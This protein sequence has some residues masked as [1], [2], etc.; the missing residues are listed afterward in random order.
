MQKEKFKEPI[1]HGTAFAP[2]KVYSFYENHNSFFVSHHWHEEIEFLYFERGDFLLER[3]MVLEEVKEGDLIFLNR[4]QMHQITGLKTPSIHHAI[5]FD[6]QVLKFE[7]YDMAQ[8]SVIAPLWNGGCH[9]LGSVGK[10][11]TG[12]KELLS[13]YQKIMEIYKLQNPG[14]RTLP[15]ESNACRSCGGSRDE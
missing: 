13:T 2:V 10:E 1:E 6:L 4:S 8:A 7:R 14:W 11:H 3:D 12:Y 9:F 5:V 15:G